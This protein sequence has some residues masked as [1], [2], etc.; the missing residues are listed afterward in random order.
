MTTRD[1]RAGIIL[2]GTDQDLP[3]T[4]VGEYEK[5]TDFK[6]FARGGK[7]ILTECYDRIIG[8]TVMMKRLLPKFADDEQEQRRFLRE[9]RVTAQLQHPN[10]VPVYEIGRDDNNSLYFTMKR[11]YGENLFEILKRIAQKDERAAEDF[12]VSR[13]LNIA[14]DTALA[15]AYAHAHG[16]VHRDVKPE[17]IWVG[18]Y[19]QVI[20]LDWGVAKVWGHSDD[21]GFDPVNPNAI[22]PSLEDPADSS[23]EQLRT[24]TRTGQLLG[25]PLYMS[26]EQVLGHKYLD[27]RTDVFSMGIVLYESLTLTEPFRG[28]NVRS[29]FDNIIHEE[30]ASPIEKRPD[31]DIPQAASDVTMK[32]LSKK[33]E[34]RYQTML[35]FVEALQ[36]AIKET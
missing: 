26:P 20:L 11:I 23:E 3:P 28:R 10:T 34:E 1:P 4:K 22:I 17:N 25:T 29:T 27:E 7:A 12:P 21:F 15:L 36:D 18:E 19:G 33:P 30:P 8:R 31:R 5:H 2:G 35:A 9:A 6:E 32:A 16:V 13:L 24:L 14:A